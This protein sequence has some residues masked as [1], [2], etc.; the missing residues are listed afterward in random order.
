VLAHTVL[1][2]VEETVVQVLHE[3]L[4]GALDAVLGLRRA[5]AG[6]HVGRDQVV[7][8]QELEVLA[9]VRGRLDTRVELDLDAGLAVLVGVQHALGHSVRR[10]DRRRHSSEVLAVVDLLREEQVELGTLLVGGDCVT[11][12]G[13]RDRGA[14][15]TTEG[16]A[17]QGQELHDVHEHVVAEVRLSAEAVQRLRQ[18]A[19]RLV[20]GQDGNRL[21]RLRHFEYLHVYIWFM[22]CPIQGLAPSIR[23]DAKLPSLSVAYFVFKER[24]CLAAWYLMAPPDPPACADE[25]EAESDAYLATTSQ[26]S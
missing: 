12:L 25:P 24:Q 19:D 18:D 13:Q 9:T 14:S 6:V 16:E 8:T 23:G 15:S 2:D 1:L 4:H 3:E 17:T 10:L 21:K 11:L 22:L 5:P 20:V 7:P 26:K